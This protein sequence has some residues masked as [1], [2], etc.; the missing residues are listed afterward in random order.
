MQSPVNQHVSRN[1]RA[2]QALLGRRGASLVLIVLLLPIFV[3]MVAFAVDFGLMTLLRAQIQNAVDAG[4]LAASLKL[5]E[6]PKAIAEAEAAAREFV[7]LNRVG[8]QITVPEDA[9]D[10][11]VGVWDDDK[12]T[13][14]ATTDEPNAVRVFA[15]QDNERYFFAQIFGHTTFGAPASAI[16]AASQLELDIMLVL[17][18][19]GSMADEGRIQALWN[20]APVFVNMVEGIGGENQ[21]GVMG[22]S[23]DPSTYKNGYDSGL[24]P[25]PD[26]HVGVLESK[27][28]DNFTALKSSVLTEKKLTPGKYQP[29]TGTGA[30]L[31]DAAHYITY[32]KEARSKAEK[33]IV[34]M[35][36]GYANRPSANGPQ[37][38][39]DMAKYAADRDITVYTISLGDDADVA[40]M[41]EMAQITGGSHFDATGSGEADLTQKLTEAFQYVTDAIKDTQL[42][43]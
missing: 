20:A 35:S 30:A 8:S 3:G 17:D 31:G 5:K 28:T 43:Q 21:I 15:R 29:W 26:H 12:Q 25:T 1:P 2:F 36:D 32:G 22:L 6:D 16:A 24:H 39:L 41:E 38:A 40:F 4:T 10:V 18:L 13:F 23:A 9:I 33:I 7:Q 34:L 11:E 42:V 14:T 27:L 19:S 37:Y